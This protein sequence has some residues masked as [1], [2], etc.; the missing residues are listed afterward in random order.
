MGL[1]DDLLAGDLG[2]H[3]GNPEQPDRVLL[4]NLIGE[5][6]S[7]YG[8]RGELHKALRIAYRGRGERI[9]GAE[10]VDAV[11]GL[12]PRAQRDD[13][14]GVDE[15]LTATGVTLPLP[16]LGDVARDD[17][18]ARRRAPRHPARAGGRRAPRR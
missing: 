2:V 16:W 17:G 8:H 1:Q 5:V 13:R 18:E 14:G 6:V 12:E 11:E 9:C 4:L 10:H 7:E 15:E 3:V